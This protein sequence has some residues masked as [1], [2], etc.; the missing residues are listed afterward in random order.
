[1]VEEKIYLTGSS[2]VD[3]EGED[4]VECRFTSYKVYY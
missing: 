3:I 1:M 4:L 2:G